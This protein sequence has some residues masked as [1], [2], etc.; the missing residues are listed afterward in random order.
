MVKFG[1]PEIVDIDIDEI[2]EY[3]SVIILLLS[4]M[5]HLGFAIESKSV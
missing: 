5:Y 2:F 4:V 1:I 3:Q